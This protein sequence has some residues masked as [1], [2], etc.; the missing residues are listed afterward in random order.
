MNSARINNIKKLLTFCG[1]ALIVEDVVGWFFL[2]FINKHEKLEHIK[3][4]T[5]CI[6]P[7]ISLSEAFLSDSEGP[8][9][10]AIEYIYDYDRD[11]EY[12]GIFRFDDD[13]VTYSD[14]IFK[15]PYGLK[16]S[17]IPDYI[18]KEI[19][20]Q[21]YQKAKKNLDKAIINAKSSVSYLEDKLK[22][23][24]QITLTEDAAE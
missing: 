8:F 23:F 5:N 15:P 1:S 7:K 16:Y 14:N 24:E 10:L 6:Y 4:E 21:V 9:P 19:E 2:D 12:T 18:W 3:Y 13:E 17:D 11:R 20:K 22:E